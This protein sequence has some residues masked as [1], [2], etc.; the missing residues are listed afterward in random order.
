MT[1]PINLE[2]LK[3]KLTPL[4]RYKKLLAVLG[5]VIA[6]FLIIL[7]AK[8][9]TGR[10]PSGVKTTVSSDKSTKA[11]ATVNI[12][13]AFEFMAVNAKKQEVPV[14][15]TIT[16]IERKDEIK[17]KGD[18]RRLT[19]GRDFV[20]V[21]IEIE[22]DATERVAIA[23]ADRVRL[24]GGGGKLFA[25]DYH[26]GNVVVDPISVRRDL[27]A[28]IVDTDVKKLTFLVG[29]LEGEKQRIEVSF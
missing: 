25:P 14:T 11:E 16:T 23:S 21:R 1:L 2:T 18:P 9:Q 3:S 17:V 8:G 12:N 7:L 20:L 6:I 5:I 28:F 10:S 24:E 13:R 27:L 19:G 15:F 22:N 26:N 4:A 29:E